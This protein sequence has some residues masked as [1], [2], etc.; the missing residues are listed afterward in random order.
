M[1]DLPTGTVTFV[2][3]DIEGSTALWER[4]PVEM[5]TA[6]ARH[7][8]L[9]EGAIGAHGGYVFKKVG[10]AVCAAFSTAPAALLAAAEA[11]RALWAEE[12]AGAPLRVRMALHT[13]SAERRDGDYLGAPL[14]RVARL[15]SAGH[16]GQVL[17]SHP[18][19]ELVRDD[20]PRGATL[21]MLGEHRLKDLIRPERVYQL[22]A[23]GLPASF[24]PLTSLE[25]RP[26]NLPAQP[27][28]LVGRE[29]EVA[30]VCALLG[31]P[32]LR[33]LTLTGPGGTGKTRLG[34]QAAA[35]LLEAFDDGVYFV[36]L[37]PV[38]DAGLVAES[39]AQAVGLRQSAD[40]PLTE[41]LK[42]ALAPASMLLVLDNFEQVLAAA[43]LVAGLLAAA[44]RL[45]ALVT[46]RSALH[47]SGEHEY[48]VQ[49]LA[50]PDSRRLPPLDR[51]T[52]YESVRLF[53]ERAQAARSDF[54]VT[55]ENAPTVAEICHRLDGLP[56]AIELAAARIRLLPPQAMLARLDSRLR[57]LTGGPRDLP[58][59]QR[60]LRGTIDWSYG[61]LDSGEQQLFARLAVFAGGC[62]LDAAESVCD[63]GGELE[64]DVL[65]GLSSLVDKSLVRTR[66][67]PDGEPRFVMLETIQ[68]YARE[69][70]RVGGEEGALR[71]RHAE[72]YLS[73]AE[74]AE[75]ELTGRNQAPWLDRLEAEHDNLRAALG[76]SLE[77]PDGERALRLAGALWRLWYSRGY[78]SEGRR[79]LEAALD[80]DG[81]GGAPAPPP[82]RA[83][84]LYGAGML[85]WDQGSYARAVELIEESLALRRRTG[86]S[87]GIAQSLNALGLVMTFRGEY[88]AATRLYEESLALKRELGDTWGTAMSL[89]NLGLTAL[90]QGDLRRATEL[91]EE[92]LALKRQLG[93]I[94]SVA[95]SLNNLGL[96]ALYGGDHEQARRWH[97]ESL[98]LKRDQGNSQGIAASVHNLG[99]LALDRGDILEAGSMLRDA[100]KRFHDL[101]DSQGMVD[102]LESLGCLAMAWRQPLRAATLWAAAESTRRLLG[103]PIPPV[104]RSFLGKWMSG[105][106]GDDA[107]VREARVRGSSMSLEQAV[108]HAMEDAAGDDAP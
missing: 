54:A 22:V 46:S 84:A 1:A 5:R 72:H 103:A 94:H 63:A 50:L 3:T 81:T 101:G 90:F 8:E 91:L 97:E 44:P 15:L 51:L 48:Q 58:A 92:S 106:R 49:P 42:A 65:D 34:L 102:A 28:P 71:R 70:L 25:T 4:Q 40:Q 80:R 45:K 107:R 53:I 62:A 76:W 12:W 32:E 31:R 33:L 85:A 60:T 9:L 43:P 38:S 73:L 52:Q 61:L 20:L 47:L 95:E 55:N 89:G 83:K 13:G 23:P 17:L 104:Q 66:E 35:E 59:R 27:T 64:T 87:W 67:G 24:P 78:L 37:A 75:P 30:E 56:L 18:T 29:R 98:E 11:Q 93:L 86:D 68:E 105:V 99:V 108:A 21:R 100:L 19:Q 36:P 10:D 74:R 16:G 2:F 26:N 82:V 41:S 96:A 79:W 69:R 14:N 39:I 6:L 7:D 77:Q 88:E 57:L